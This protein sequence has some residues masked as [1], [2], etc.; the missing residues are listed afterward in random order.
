MAFAR[1]LYVE[2][3]EDNIYMLSQRLARRGYEVIV[4]RDGAEG[5]AMA[6]AEMPALILMDLS[7]PVLDG[8]AATR[9]LKSS[10]RTG[11]LPVIALSSHAMA[12]EREA[13]LA[14]GCDEFQAKPV[15]FER[16]IG[17]IEA[18]LRSEP[19]S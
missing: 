19:G 18:L 7:L 11:H 5:V 13:A 9:R 8:W 17:K 4:A 1:I 14:A 6:E 2:D 15:D 10:P 12:G 16:L 3:N